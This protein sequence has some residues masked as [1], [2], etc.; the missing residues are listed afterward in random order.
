MHQVNTA[1][2]NDGIVKNATNPDLG[3]PTLADGTGK[4]VVLENLMPFAESGWVN[5]SMAFSHTNDAA[6]DLAILYQGP[7]SRGVI[8]EKAELCAISTALADPDG[9]FFI[10]LQSQGL[11]YLPERAAGHWFLA[12]EPLAG[13]SGL[14]EAY[15][16]QEHEFSHKDPL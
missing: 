2:N 6:S 7:C 15:Q 1:L 8:G 12:F 4:I 13:Q 14:A 3:F 16:G 5:H 10:L 11:H 9:C